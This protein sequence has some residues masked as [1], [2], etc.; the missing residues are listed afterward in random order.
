MQAA[1]TR[2]FDLTSR[3]EFLQE[4]AKQAVLKVSNRFL[5]GS[6]KPAEQ[7]LSRK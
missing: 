7:P 5:Q 1:L 3:A 2:Q 4:F 6:P